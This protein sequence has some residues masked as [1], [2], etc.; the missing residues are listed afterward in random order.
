MNSWFSVLILLC[1]SFVCRS[2]AP[3]L[4][5]AE[6]RWA[7]WHPFSAVKVRKISRQCDRIY[8][9][10]ENRK[11]LDDFPGGGKLDAYRHVFYMAAFAQKIRVKKV[12]KLGLAHEKN[13]Y[14]Q[15]RQAQKEQGEVPDSLSSVMDLSNNELGI[16]L[17]CNF[18]KLPLTELSERSIADINAGKAL[19][20]KRNEKGDY[21]DCEGNLLALS[22]FR[23]KWS[24][25]KC[26]VRS[27]YKP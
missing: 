18:R 6:L 25:P 9:V 8:L 17:G 19:I 7:V 3:R 1:I 15:F 11:K 2:Q 10:D 26:L 22:S 23:G 24:V 27:D 20:M 4:S 12:R 13:N 14:R 21:L 5:A 16:S